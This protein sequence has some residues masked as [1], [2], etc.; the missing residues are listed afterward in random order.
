LDDLEASSKLNA[1]WNFFQRLRDA[2]RATAQRWLEK[3]Y[4]SIGREATLDLPQL[5]Q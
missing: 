4:D 2:G 3:H 5:Y 1:E